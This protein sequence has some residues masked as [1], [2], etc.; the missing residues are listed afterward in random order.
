MTRSQTDIVARME[1]IKDED[2]MGFQRDVLLG[3]LDYEH[4]KP[5]LKPEATAEEWAEAM[6]AEDPAVAGAEYLQF[7]IGKARDHRGISA[8]RSVDKLTMYAWLAGRDDVVAAMDEADYANY[9]VPK[10]RAF[11]EGMSCSWPTDAELD[12]MSR[13]AG[14]GADYEC[15]CF[16]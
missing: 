16:S 13:G 11:A 10:L 5:Y 9:G 2:W 15:G 3:Y 8:S 7:A 6:T 1:A 12:G 4:A 14:C